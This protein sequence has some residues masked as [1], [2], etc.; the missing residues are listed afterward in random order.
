MSVE[1]SASSA[2]SLKAKVASYISLSYLTN[3]RLR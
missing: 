3:Y 2:T 1:A